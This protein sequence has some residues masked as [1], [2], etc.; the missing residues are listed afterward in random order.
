MLPVYNTYKIA[1]NLILQDR[2][3]IQNTTSFND[4]SQA[5]S[6]IRT[7]S[8]IY[9]L[10]F[11]TV[12]NQVYIYDIKQYQ[13]VSNFTINVSRILGKFTSCYIWNRY[14]YKIYILTLVLVKDS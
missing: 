3:N 8:V 4:K 12:D 13:K 10:L 2:Q 9:T 1:L 6:E 14:R 5:H 11:A 7:I